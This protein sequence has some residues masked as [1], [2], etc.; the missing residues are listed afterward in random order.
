MLVPFGLLSDRV[1]E[2]AWRLLNAGAYLGALTWWSGVVLPVTLS[3]SQRAA[4]FLLVVPLSVGSLHNGQSNALVMACLLAGVAAVASQRWNLAAACVTLAAWWKLYPVAV[5]LLLTAAYPRRFAGRWTLMMALGCGLPF[6]AQRPTYVATQFRD[7]AAVLQSDDRH[8]W[9][10]DEAYRDLRLVCRV[11]LRPLSP[12]TYRAVQVATGAIIAAVC[13]ARRRTLASQGRFL[14]LLLSLACCWMTV[15]GFATESCT[16]LLLAPA[17]AWA[18]LESWVQPTRWQW[19]ALL[20]ASYGLFLATQLVIA[21][22]G[23]R[24]W[25][26]WGP[27]PVAGLM[28]FGCLMAA[29][30]G[31]GQWQGTDHAHTKPCAHDT[32]RSRLAA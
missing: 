4:L 8:D 10:L 5:G 2:I 26:N 7:W 11:W 9:A 28:L 13:L 22:G 17:L 30:G 18:V 12:K 29:A 32:V 20:L 15:F 27:Q 19:R 16:Y 21:I 14:T 31:C 3:R 25:S 1:G 23:G 24:H 6:L